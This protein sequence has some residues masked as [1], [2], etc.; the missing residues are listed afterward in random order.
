MFCFNCT[1]VSLQRSRVGSR[2]VHRRV[3]TLLD[4]LSCLSLFFTQGHPQ[5]LDSLERFKGFER[6]GVEEGHIP[7]V[8]KT[9]LLSLRVVQQTFRH[10]R[11]VH[12]R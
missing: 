9:A 4:F 1:Y 12:S 8:D 11:Y 10:L 2:V 7:F 6:D 3:Q 5:D